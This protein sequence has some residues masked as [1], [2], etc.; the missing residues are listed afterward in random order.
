MHFSTRTGR[1]NEYWVENSAKGIAGEKM[2]ALARAL[3]IL[4]TATEKGRGRTL[5]VQFI[6]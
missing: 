5:N 3:L 1:K 4:S 6:E 2:E